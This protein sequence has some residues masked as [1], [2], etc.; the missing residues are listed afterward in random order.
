M[1]II[2]QNI[3]LRRKELGITQRELAEKL[4]IS[5][6]TLSRWETDKQ[7][8][9]ALMIPEIAK[10]LDMSIGE[11]YG[12][13]QATDK[14][15][16]HQSYETITENVFVREEI[17]YARITAYKIVLLSAA[18]L[19]VLGSG[20]YS[21]MGVLWNH[22]K[23]GAL[24][25]LV[26][27]LA[28]FLIGELTFEDF[29]HRKDNPAVYEKIHQRWFGISTPLIGLIIGIVIPALKAPVITMFNNWDAILPLIFFQGSVL[30]LYGRTGEKKTRL[31]HIFVGVGIACI[32]GFL[33]N[34]ANNPYRYM[35]GYTYEQWE[36]ASL[37]G[38]IKFFEFA[39]G[40]VFF[41]MN[42]LYSKDVLGI[43]GTILKKTAKI[44]GIAVLAVSA[45]A[46][47]CIHINNKNL[48]SRVTYISGEVPMYELTNYSYELI[49]WIQ[50]CNLSGEEICM[51]KSDVYKGEGEMA[52]AYL[53]YLP[54][55]YEETELKIRYRVGLGENVLKIETENTTQIADDNYYLC[56]VEILN[57]WENYEVQTYLNGERTTYWEVSSSSIWNIFE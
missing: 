26:V 8:P 37:W 23:F 20:I 40:F 3:A 7:V 10:V 6:K 47:V 14:K 45:I 53:I 13:D 49:D 46:A 5:D 18:F 1:N 35:G 36:L 54:H 34:V 27:G 28:V 25:L 32:V 9:D 19:L 4:N 31:H 15:K 52:K 57:P 50:E 39:C 48:Q 43:Y 22:V 38:R 41:F 24:V 42:V 12:I 55:G 51:R 21:F 29:R 17:D 16:K 30:I 11:I 2:A 56:Y 44:V 33:I